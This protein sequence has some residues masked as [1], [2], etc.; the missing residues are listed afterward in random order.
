MRPRWQVSNW[1]HQGTGQV[2]PSPIESSPIESN[3][4]RR[5]AQSQ[6]TPETNFGPT[7]YQRRILSSFSHIFGAMKRAL[8]RALKRALNRALKRAL[9]RAC[10]LPDIGRIGVLKSDKNTSFG[11][12]IFKIRATQW[13]GGLFKNSGDVGGYP[14]FARAYSAL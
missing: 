14:M 9:N 1:I 6:L 4:R 12:S 3:R 8:N 11:A 13:S 10:C 5:R 7:E 2:Q